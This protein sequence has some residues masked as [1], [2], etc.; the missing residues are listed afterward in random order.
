[1][2]HI[3]LTHCEEVLVKAILVISAAILLIRV[4]IIGIRDIRSEM[5]ER[6]KK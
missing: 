6:D 5:R 1:M 3:D 2:P 4:T